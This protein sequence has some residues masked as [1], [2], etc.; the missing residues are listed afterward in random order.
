MRSGCYAVAGCLGSRVP[1][2]SVF[3]LLGLERVAGTCFIPFTGVL[4]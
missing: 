1:V 2:A 4:Q 3:S